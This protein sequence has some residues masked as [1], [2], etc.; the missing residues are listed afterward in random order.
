[1]PVGIAGSLPSCYFLLFC[2][3]QSFHQSLLLLGFF[4]VLWREEFFS[5]ENK[6]TTDLLL[7]KI[8]YKKNPSY[9]GA[10]AQVRSH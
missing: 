3:L 5:R 10:S 7:L 4:C 6:S 2:Y 1:M 9:F 8:I